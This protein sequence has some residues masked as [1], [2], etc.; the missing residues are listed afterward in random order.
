MFGPKSTDYGRVRN[1][2]QNI[3]RQFANRPDFL[4]AHIGPGHPVIDVRTIEEADFFRRRF[5]LGIEGYPVE[6]DVQERAIP[7]EPPSPF[8]PVGGVDVKA[9]GADTG[10]LPLQILR[11]LFNERGLKYYLRYLHSAEEDKSTPKDPM[12]AA[13]LTF[14]ADML[15]SLSAYEKVDPYFYQ[16]MARWNKHRKKLVPFEFMI[17]KNVSAWTR[18][19]EA[20]KVK[21]GVVIT[22]SS[23]PSPYPP[24]DGFVGVGDLI[25]SRDIVKE[26]NK[27]PQWILGA[28][29]ELS[30]KPGEGERTVYGSIQFFLA[31]PEQIFELMEAFEKDFDFVKAG[32]LVE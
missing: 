31:N 28:G 13:G 29:G 25:T 2:A 1:L 8:T 7:M 4:S 32:F 5:R 9:L 14:E 11:T 24:A 30:A 20:L 3:Q 12:P 16:A 15:R 23:P 26:A 27:R 6:V 22:A 10:P 18:I 17:A 21:E 19:L